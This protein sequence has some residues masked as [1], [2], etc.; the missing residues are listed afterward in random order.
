MLEYGFKIIG[1]Q[2]AIAISY[3]E[4]FQFQQ[5]LKIHAGILY[6]NDNLSVHPKLD[7]FL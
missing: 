1:V 4:N 3:P 5:G 7:A 6:L 2:L